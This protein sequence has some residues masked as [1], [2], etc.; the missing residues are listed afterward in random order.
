MFV[1]WPEPAWP[2]A[3]LEVAWRSFGLCPGEKGASLAWVIG[4]IL[5]LVKKLLALLSL[6]QATETGRL[7]RLTTAAWAKSSDF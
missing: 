3:S 4:G 5:S 6:A 1:S 7:G 2:E